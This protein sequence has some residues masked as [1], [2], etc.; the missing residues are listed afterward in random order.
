VLDDWLVLAAQGG[1]ASAF[2]ALASRWNRRLVAHAYRRIGHA[3]GAAEAS[4]E[5]WMAIVRGLPTLGDPARFPAWACRIVDRKA[6]DW[7]RRRRRSRAIDDRLG[8]DPALRPQT[9]EPAPEADDPGADSDALAVERLR[10]LLRELP[11]EQRALL[12]M[13]Y[14]DGRSVREIAQAMGIPE[15]TV[16]SRLFHARKSLKTRMGDRP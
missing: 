1:D 15:G 8:H 7:L 4:Q 14:A 10:R 12:G 6:V 11:P 9:V 2:E 16:K 5:A 13:F 3:E